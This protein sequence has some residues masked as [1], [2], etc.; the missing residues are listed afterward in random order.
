MIKVRPVVR[1]H[2]HKINLEKIHKVFYLFDP[3]HYLSSYVPSRILQIHI[4]FNAPTWWDDEHQTDIQ[5]SY[6]PQDLIKEER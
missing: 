1:S 6:V 3:W 4:Y 5:R 2:Y